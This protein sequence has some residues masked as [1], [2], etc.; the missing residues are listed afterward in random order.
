MMRIEVSRRKDWPHAPT[1]RLDSRG[2]YVSGYSFGL[3][4]AGLGEKD[5]AFRWLERAYQDRAQEL[6]RLKVDPLLD[7][8][9]S[10]P[11][12]ADLVRRVGLNP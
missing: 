6:S 4:Y 7:N 12:F 3:V 10:D 5:Q 8:L 2:V 11:R 9:R 1:H